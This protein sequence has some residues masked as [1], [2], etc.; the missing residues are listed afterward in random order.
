M[1]FRA[2][3]LA[4]ALLAA[5]FLAPAACD[6]SCRDEPA[7]CKTIVSLPVA[8][9]SPGEGQSAHAVFR[10][11]EGEEPL[12][13]LR[14]Q[15][16]CDVHSAGDAVA[17]CAE[18]IAHLSRRA[19]GQ[20]DAPESAR[21][22]PPAPP[23][24]SASARPC[25][26]EA[27]AAVE[28]AWATVEGRAGVSAAGLL[29]GDPPAE[30]AL[31]QLTRAGAAWPLCADAPFNRG[32]M[33][34]LLGLV[35]P[36]GDAHAR[37]AERARLRP[38]RTHMPRVRTGAPGAGPGRPGHP[39][40]R[41]ATRF[42]L[43]HDFEQLTWLR[44]RMGAT[45]FNAAPLSGD[46]WLEA[47]TALLAANPP[48]VPRDGS[49]VVLAGDAWAA[50]ERWHNRPVWPAR[51]PRL[52]VGV[53]SPALRAWD[54]PTL[55][56]GSRGFP[57]GGRE[58]SAPVPDRGDRPAQTEMREVE[59]RE[60]ELREVELREVELREVERRYVE[61]GVVVVD[62]LLTPRALSA[63][64]EWCVEATLWFDANPQGY[65]GA[66]FE[67][68]FA[69]PLLAQ[70]VEEMRAALP[71]I[72]SPHNLTEV[73]AYKYDS[74]GEGIRI[75]ADSAAVNV[76][77]WITPDEANL[78]PSTGGLLVYPTAEAPQGWGFREYNSPEGEAEMVKM[79]E[80][81]EKVRVPY[82]QNR[83]VI[84]NSSMLHRTDEFRFKRGFANRRINLTFLFGE[85][86]G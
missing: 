11:S 24:A 19:L 48:V 33:L 52:D 54:V 15:E 8:V 47:L 10:L 65:V 41:K 17:A 71:G 30:D 6:G 32:V 42:K 27:H 56:R 4:A 22:G 7:R 86:G 69:S 16:F 2:A 75:H 21:D 76:N 79:A 81:G 60:V 78:D 50:V 59:M 68:G 73:W 83:A 34:L 62:S 63:L 35:G 53:L 39:M 26:P 3:L 74:E 23:E 80:R 49:P 45:R 61:D 20:V 9:D 82:R 25:P 13:D 43:R 5:A 67:A 40:L 36:A 12:I 29:R 70:V 66:Y 85:R 37:A 31:A 84:F 57:T 55:R 46:A 72:L 58:S 28:A 38:S 77:F 51:P 44:G 64:F 18:Q 14:A 1:S